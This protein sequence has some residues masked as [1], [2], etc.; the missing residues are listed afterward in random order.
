M[1][2]SLLISA[3]VWNL[4]TWYL[5]L[6]ASSS[7][8]LIG[9]IMGVGVMNSLMNS[10]GIANG[11][12]WPQVQK[13]G[14]TLLISPL[15]GFICTA[16]LFLL[17]KFLIRKPELYVAPEPK[18]APPWWIRIL[19]WFTCGGV[20]FAHGSN[21]GQKGMGLLM[22][23]LVGIVPGMY[24]LDLSTSSDSLA[25]IAAM[26]QNASAII[27]KHAGGEPVEKTAAA[28]TLSD[29]LKTS[30]TFSDQI[31]PALAEKN[32]EIKPNSQIA[33]L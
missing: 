11:I 33:N 20:S 8:T 17:V 24:A 22:L 16:I 9:S 2:F 30:G 23:I 25:K 6:P 31:F 10:G 18:K 29:Y 32:S 15:V 1:V 3:I 5:G 28:K 14:L 4:G 12:N 7:H 27:Q 13:V 19:L 21:D 26:S